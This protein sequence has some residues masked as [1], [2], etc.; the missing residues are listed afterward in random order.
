MEGSLSP[1]HANMRQ[2]G[3]RHRAGKGETGYAAQRRGRGAGPAESRAL[4]SLRGR[5]PEAHI[6]SHAL[7]THGAV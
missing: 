2:R 4:L 7:G 3:G 6:M 1:R 5:F